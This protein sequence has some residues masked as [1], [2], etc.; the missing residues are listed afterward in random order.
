MSIEKMPLDVGAQMKYV[1]EGLKDFAKAL[2]GKQKISLAK[3]SR[4]Q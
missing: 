1:R 3:V 4:R 2:N